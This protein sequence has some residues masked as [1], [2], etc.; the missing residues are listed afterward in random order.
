MFFSSNIIFQI[1]LA[2][3][4]AFAVSLI[5]VP[6]VIKFA[7]KAK[8]MDDPK[9]HI[10]PAILH[11]KPIPRAGG[12][13]VFI[14]IFVAAL[15]FIPFDSF[16][17]A[18]FAGGLVVVITGVLD[19]KYDLSPYIRFAINILTA[20]IA[21]YAGVTIPFITNPL[22]GMLYFTS[23]HFTL[24][25]H[26]FHI[27]DLFAIVWIVWVMNMLNWSKGVDGQMPGIAA[28]SAFVIGIAALRFVPLEHLTFVTSLISF[29]VG[30]AS[31]GFLFFNFYPAR[32]FPGYSATILG[33]FIGIL[34]ITSGVKLATAVL[35]MGVPCVDAVLTII[36]RLM[37]KKSPFWHDRGH[38]HHLLLNYGM[39]H[40]SIAVFYWLMS[41][42]LGAVALSASSRGKLF[43]IILVVVVVAGFV[44]ML[45]IAGKRQEYD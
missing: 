12:V 43:A 2:T 31:L 1:I 20:G 19:D 38:L 45:R 35:V 34:S 7:K 16:L 6:F 26:V 27:G 33:Y 25:S 18:I 24:L 41:L 28:I 39:G 36:R 8:L 44:F 22:G 11:K 13:A 29:M 4:T 10:H 32:I 9:T 15:I 30:G 21:V 3:L 40:R 37:S 23:F 42:V 5:C 17:R 14:G